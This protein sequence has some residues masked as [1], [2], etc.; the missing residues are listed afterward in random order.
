LDVLATIK[1]EPEPA[2]GFQTEHAVAYE[3]QL[4]PTDAELRTGLDSTTR[5]WGHQARRA[6]QHRQSQS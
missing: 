1:G 2:K 4:R 6:R 5:D 3:R